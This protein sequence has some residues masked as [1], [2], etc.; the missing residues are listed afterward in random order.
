MTGPELTAARATLGE[1]WG[2]GRPLHAAELAR[3]LRLSGVNARQSVA[4]WERGAGPTGAA[5]VA[6]EMMLAG[7][8]PPDDLDKIIVRTKL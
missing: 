2:L 8:R 3:A 7:A 6:V 1:M 5:S 4:G